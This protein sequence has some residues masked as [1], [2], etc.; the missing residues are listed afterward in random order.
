MLVYFHKEQEDLSTFETEVAKKLR[1]VYLVI[2]SGM[3]KTVTIA[4]KKENESA[5]TLK[6]EKCPSYIFLK[7]SYTGD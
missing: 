4:C 1:S 7:P 2:F 3:V 6:V 5:K